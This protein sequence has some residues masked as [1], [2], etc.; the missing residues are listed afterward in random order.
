MVHQLS[1]YF[2]SSSLFLV[3]PLPCFVPVG[4][5][6]GSGTRTEETFFSHSF[7]HFFS[8]SVTHGSVYCRC[9]RKHHR[10]GEWG[11]RGGRFRVSVVKTQS[12]MV[13]GKGE[14]PLS[15]WW[16]HRE[17]MLP[18]QWRDWG[19]HQCLNSED[20]G[21]FNACTM[22]IHGNSACVGEILKASASAGKV[23]TMG[24][25]LVQAWNSHC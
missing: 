8:D 12:W 22:N 25:N 3:P 15:R 9:G 6:M 4:Q 11:L 14:E 20:I 21:Q 18:G 2:C 23:R 10:Y 17:V 16:R 13:K 7:P 19:M 5:V 24:L 1:H